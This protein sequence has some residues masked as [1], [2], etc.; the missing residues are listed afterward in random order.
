MN[1]THRTCRIIVVLGAAVLW[2]SAQAGDVYRCQVDEVTV[3]S[4]QPCEEGAAPIEPK[5]NLSVIPTSENVEALS[6]SNREWMEAYRA[7]QTRRHAAR[8]EARAARESAERQARSPAVVQ[9]VVLAPPAHRFGRV[10]PGRAKDRRGHRHSEHHQEREES[11]PPIHQ[12]RR[13]TDLSRDRSRPRA[14]DLHR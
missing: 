6:K 10:P 9:P 3:F 2:T 14:T 4:D 8:A 5:G 12:R 13:A 1:A 11:S 7:D